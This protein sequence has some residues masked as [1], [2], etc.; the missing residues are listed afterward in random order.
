MEPIT[1]YRESTIDLRW[2]ECRRVLG[3]VL[4]SPEWAS[5][6]ARI[7]SR[8]HLLFAVAVKH[9]ETAHE[10]VLFRIIGDSPDVRHA[11]FGFIEIR[12]SSEGATSLTVMVAGNLDDVPARDHMAV[13][14]AVSGRADVLGATIVA[15]VSPPAEAVRARIVR[16]A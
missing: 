6:R 2:T 8:G 3:E 10:S 9:V 16:Y 13:Q 5:E 1:A 7:V 15:A 12:P 4:T 14:E 11:L